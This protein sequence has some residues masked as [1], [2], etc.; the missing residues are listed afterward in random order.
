MEPPRQRH[1]RDPNRDRAAR[2]A[3]QAYLRTL[4][5]ALSASESALMAL[6]RGALA[7]VPD[8]LRVAGERLAEAQTELAGVTGAVAQLQH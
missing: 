7:D 5:S 4:R 1:L 8:R 3:L 6:D 2:A